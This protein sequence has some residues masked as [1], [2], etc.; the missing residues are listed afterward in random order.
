MKLFELRKASYQIHKKNRLKNWILGIVFIIISC[1]LLSFSLFIGGIILILPVLI[2]PLFFAFVLFHLIQNEE[3]E[4]VYSN[5]FKLGSLYVSPRFYGVLRFF[6]SYFVSLLIGLLADVIMGFILFFVFKNNYDPIF[7][8]SIYNLRDNIGS[9]QDIET[10]NQLING[11][12]N[13]LA[14]FLFWV[15]IGGNFLMF[16]FFIYFI[17]RHSV[18]I[19]FR[20]RMI[21]NNPF[22]DRQ[23]FKHFIKNNRWKFFKVRLYL[24]YPLYLLMLIGYIVGIIIGYNNFNTYSLVFAFGELLCLA[25]TIFFI[26]F[27]FSNNEA[28]ANL[29]MKE[30]IDSLSKV[31]NNYAN[32]FKGKQTTIYVNQDSKPE[33]NREEPTKEENKKK[34]LSDYGESG[35]DFED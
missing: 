34:D 4:L 27:V 33:E 26:P 28:L 23:A 10:Y 9:V 6:F 19:V 29:Y 18:A 22:I 35:I 24:Y 3:S 1:A 16:F 8:Q 7:M 2:L 30:Y 32:M 25:F 11:I 17:I 31:A 14:S 5:I 20:A 12:D 13:V 21:S 15:S